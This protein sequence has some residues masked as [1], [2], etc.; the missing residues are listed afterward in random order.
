M[1]HLKSA[2][3]PALPPELT[4]PGRILCRKGDGISPGGGLHM[5]EREDL[6]LRSSCTGLL[7]PARRRVLRPAAWRSAPEEQR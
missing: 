1:S 4:L 6:A 5:V 3:P 2:A 7:G